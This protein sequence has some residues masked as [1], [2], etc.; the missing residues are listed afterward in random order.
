MHKEILASKAYSV[1]RRGV[2][3]DY[4]DLYVGLKENLT[5]LAEIIEMAKEKYSEAFNDRLFLE[6]LL[7]L[8]DIEE[9]EIIMLNSQKPTKEELLDFFTEK[10]GEFKL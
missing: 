2:Y 1:G 5:S 3:K 8:D 4:V 9:I 6:Q 7:Y 10:I